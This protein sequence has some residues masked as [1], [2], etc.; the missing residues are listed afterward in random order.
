MPSPAAEDAGDPAD[1]LHAEVARRVACG[2]HRFEIDA[3]TATGTV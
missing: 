2:E 1:F 3:T